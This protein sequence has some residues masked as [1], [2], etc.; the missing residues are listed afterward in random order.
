M[1]NEAEKSFNL[2]NPRI[3]QRSVSKEIIGEN[4]DNLCP[5]Y[6]ELP[7]GSIKS[8]HY[9]RSLLAATSIKSL[10]NIGV[11]DVVICL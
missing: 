10:T 3:A 5:V 2:Q 7:S 6:G 8:D 9:W 1:L 4:T 11:I